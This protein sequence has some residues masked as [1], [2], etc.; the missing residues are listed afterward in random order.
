MS[1]ATPDWAT[2]LVDPADKNRTYTPADAAES[3]N[4][5][6]RGWV[7][8]REEPSATKA[9]AAPLNKAAKAPESK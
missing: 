9:A 3:V 5:R 4:L 8:Q 6:A 2:T 7:T 1:N